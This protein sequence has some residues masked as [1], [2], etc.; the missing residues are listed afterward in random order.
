VVVAL[1]LAA[2]LE[3]LEQRLRTAE[4][5]LKKLAAED[6]MRKAIGKK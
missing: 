3:E 1:E 6:Q 4:R 2:V 5:S